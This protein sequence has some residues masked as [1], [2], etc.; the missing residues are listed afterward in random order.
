M[1][2]RKLSKRI[3]LDHRYIREWLLALSAAGYITYDIDTEFFSMSDEQ[4][5]VLG[6]EK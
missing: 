4:Y 5:S 6:D 1:F 3:N 2:I